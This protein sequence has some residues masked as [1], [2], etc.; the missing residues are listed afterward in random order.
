MQCNGMECNAVQCNGQG[1]DPRRGGLGMAVCR[2]RISSLNHYDVTVDGVGPRRA[3]PRPHADPPRHEQGRRQGALRAGGR[4][5]RRA[6]RRQGDGAR[7]R[8][9]AQADQGDGRPALS[10][11]RGTTRR[12]SSKRPR[13]APKSERDQTWAPR[14]SSWACFLLLRTVVAR[15]GVGKVGEGRPDRSPGSAHSD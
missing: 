11:H 1:V 13:R 3:R 7:A 8:H 2:I 14:G 9:Q 6:R 12:R 10:A 15:R 4:A 5:P